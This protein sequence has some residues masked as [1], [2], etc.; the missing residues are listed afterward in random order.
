L[1]H[2]HFGGD[3]IQLPFLQESTCKHVSFISKRVSHFFLSLLKNLSGGHLHL[4]GL[5]YRHIVSC[6]KYLHSL[7]VD[8]LEQAWS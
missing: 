8:E 6:V 3:P 4:K 5:G 7:L 2:L 1:E